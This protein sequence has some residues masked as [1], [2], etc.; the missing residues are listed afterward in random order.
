MPSN[1]VFV[2]LR[3]TK[4]KRRALWENS[5]K[6]EVSRSTLRVNSV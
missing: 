2:F 5:H 3:K 6:T 4:T 1:M